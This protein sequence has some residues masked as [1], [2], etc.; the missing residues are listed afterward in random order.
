M[1][2]VKVLLN[3]GTVLSNNYDAYRYLTDTLGFTPHD[4]EVVLTSEDGYSNQLKSVT[5]AYHEYE[6]LYDGVIVDCRNLV[7]ELECV[8]ERLKSGKSGKGYTKL[9]IA[10]QIK[11]IVSENL[12]H[13]L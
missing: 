9:D 2:E 5:D 11:R 13:W 3:D 4:L 12:D 8:I 6:L 10:Q 1:E 7:D